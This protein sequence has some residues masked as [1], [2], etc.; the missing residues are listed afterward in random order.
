MFLSQLIERLK[1]ICETEGD[2]PCDIYVSN[3]RDD[4]ETDIQCRITDIFVRTDKY[5][6]N[7]VDSSELGLMVFDKKLHINCDVM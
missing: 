3:P 4:D 6:V 7:Q 2:V 5:V 1:L